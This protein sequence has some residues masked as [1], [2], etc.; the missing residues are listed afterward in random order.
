MPIIVHSDIP[1]PAVFDRRRE[2]VL[3]SQE[4]GAT[5][6]TIKE[7]E[8]HPGWEG[9][10][11]T[12]STDIAIMVMVGAVQIILDEEIRTIRPGCTL[13]APPGCPTQ[14]NQPAMGAGSFAGHLSQFAAGHRLLG[15]D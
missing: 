1:R 10:L 8:L 13:L 3:V 15:V 11:H 7:V 6:L 2:R 5:S 4:D 9:R 12:H 14:A